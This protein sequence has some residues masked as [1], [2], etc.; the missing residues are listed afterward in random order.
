MNKMEVF[1]L[2]STSC[3]SAAKVEMIVALCTIHA[4]ID[5]NMAN[6]SFNEKS[7]FVACCIEMKKII[8]TQSNRAYN[9]VGGAMKNAVCCCSYV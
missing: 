9:K 5:C 1:V 2:L 7:R 3:C 6:I 8:A 4:V